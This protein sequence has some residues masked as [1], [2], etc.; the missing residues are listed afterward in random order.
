MLHVIVCGIYCV[1]IGSLP[2]VG[3]SDLWTDGMHSDHGIR[4]NMG[5]RKDGLEDAG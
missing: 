5:G 3:D 2:V 1:S 4:F